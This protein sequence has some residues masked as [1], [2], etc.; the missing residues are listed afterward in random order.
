MTSFFQPL[1]LASQKLVD[2]FLHRFPPE[3]SELTFTNLF[4]WRITISF[5]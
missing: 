1:S 4:I 3:I 5:R 2:D